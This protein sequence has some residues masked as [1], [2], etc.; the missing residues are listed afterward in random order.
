[1]GTALAGEWNLGPWT[2]QSFLKVG[3]H[4]YWRWS[5]E[6]P[7]IDSKG[8]TPLVLNMMWSWARLKLQIPV[9]FLGVNLTFFPEHSF[10]FMSTCFCMIHLNSTVA[11]SAWFF[12]WPYSVR[13]AEEP[14]GFW[15]NCWLVNLWCYT[16]SIS[17]WPRKL[18]RHTMVCLT[19]SVNVLLCKIISKSTY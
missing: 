2:I 15:W 5:L 11:S 13:G 9:I 4:L 18:C 12:K 1:M 14:L 16:T 6:V 19:R 7:T 8:L 10:G 3:N 17:V